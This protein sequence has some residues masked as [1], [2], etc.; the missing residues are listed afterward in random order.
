MDFT[1]KKCHFRYFDITRGYI[2]SPYPTCSG[3]SLH[4]GDTLRVVHTG[5]RAVRADD[6]DLRA[7]P[8]GGGVAAAGLAGG[9]PRAGLGETWALESWD[10]LGDS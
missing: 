2:P 7:R 4:A 1:I 8:R 6:A 10:V 9:L 5:L 3:R